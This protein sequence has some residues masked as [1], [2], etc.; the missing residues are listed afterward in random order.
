MQPPGN[1]EFFRRR[2]RVPDVGVSGQRSQLDRKRCDD[3]IL[4]LSHNPP[5]EEAAFK[6]A[7]G[8]LQARRL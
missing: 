7:L 3:L 6:R 4:D 2:R 1:F 5:T 8:E